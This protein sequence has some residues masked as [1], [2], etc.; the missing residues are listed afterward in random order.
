MAWINHSAWER[1]VWKKR[2]EIIVNSVSA[3]LSLKDQLGMEMFYFSHGTS[4][5]RGADYSTPLSSFLKW[6]PVQNINIRLRGSNRRG[7]VCAKLRTR[8]KCAS[9]SVR[10]FSYVCKTMHDMTSMTCKA[11]RKNF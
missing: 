10:P 6:S 11:S 4:H 3:F 7:S 9:M 2:F 1:N 8:L 5:G